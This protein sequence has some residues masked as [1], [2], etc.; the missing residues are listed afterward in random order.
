MASEAHIAG[1][2]ERMI[3]PES[4]SRKYVYDQAGNRT[5]MESMDGITEYIYDNC[6]RLQ[7]TVTNGKRTSFSYDACGNLLSD[8]HQSYSYDE[9]NRLSSV[10]T[11]DGNTFV[12]H[13]D[14][15]GLRHEVE[16]DGRLVQFIFNHK[17]Q[18]ITEESSDIGITRYLRGL[19]LIGSD[20]ENART[21]YHYVSD[22]NGSIAYILNKQSKIENEYQYDAFGNIISS[23]ENIA[24]IFCYCGEQL[25]AGTAQYYLR[26]RFY[27]P[28]IGRFSQQDTYLNDG[29]NL[30]A[31]CQNNPVS[32]YDPTGHNVEPAIEHP[33]LPAQQTPQYPM[34]IPQPGDLQP[35]IRNNDYCIIVIRYCRCRILKCSKQ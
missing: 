2:Q 30:Y 14:A 19:D 28:V 29:L 13:Y 18:I 17:R 7:T 5:R 6:N 25:D 35:A 21:Y 33:E 23:K 20:I 16:E 22:T 31:Y 24:N 15:E 1:Q 10:T 11:A 12:H 27:N 8:G 34:V 26:A 4:Y 3:L 9:L 32:F